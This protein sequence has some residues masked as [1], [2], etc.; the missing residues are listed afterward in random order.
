LRE[1]PHQLL[2]FNLAFVGFLA[3]VLF[4][5]F[6]LGGLFL[7]S[8][9]DTTNWVGQSLTADKKQLVKTCCYEQ[10]NTGNI[11]RK[12]NHFI[13]LILCL[14]LSFTIKAQSKDTIN[15]YIFQDTARFHTVDE[16]LNI[17]EIYLSDTSLIVK[18]FT[19]LITGGLIGLSFGINEGNKF[20][21]ELKTYFEKY[22][23]V[24][25]SFAFQDFVIEDKQKPNRNIFVRVLAYNFRKL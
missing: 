18:K 9:R 14:S 21:L 2:F 25:G 1:S 4:S 6:V 5:S 13:Y 8:K 11:M 22:K 19:W 24:D 3:L 20:N 12:Y 23:K 7:N 16:A 17:G 10:E 15:A